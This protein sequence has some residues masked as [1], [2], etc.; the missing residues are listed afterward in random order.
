MIAQQLATYTEPREQ[1]M[2]ILCDDQMIHGTTVTPYS[3]KMMSLLHR[4]R[5]LIGTLKGQRPHSQG[6]RKGSLTY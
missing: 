5:F 6:M 3:T 2:I 1:H 4:S